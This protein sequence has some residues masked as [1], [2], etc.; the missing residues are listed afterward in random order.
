[1]ASIFK[2]PNGTW[3]YRV[4]I[5]IDPSTGKRKQKY[6]SGFSTQKK[7]KLAASQV[8]IDVSEKTYVPDDL[9]TFGQFS[10]EWLAIYSAN[11]KPTSRKIRQNQIHVLNRFFKRIRLQDITRR[12]YQKALTSL[13]SDGMANNT[14]SGIHAAARMI[15]K[16]A[17]EF[18]VIADNPTDFVKPPKKN[19]TVDEVMN[20]NAK[21]LEKD[22]LIHFLNTI[23]KENEY[24]IYELF[25]L[26]AY[27]GMR[28]GELCALT[29][30][31]IDFM[32]KTV[33]ISK[34]IYNDNNHRT[35]EF[36]PPKTKR[37]IRTIIVDDVV[38]SALSAYQKQQK[39]Y[40]MRFADSYYTK[41]PMVFT[42]KKFP[43]YP[44]AR[45]YIEWKIKYYL[46]KAG[47]PETFTPHSLRHTHVSL[48]AEAGV[49]LYD[50]MDRLGHANDST[51]RE[52]YLHVTKEKKKTASD[53]FAALLTE[54]ALK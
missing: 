14:L 45:T 21:Y 43:G 49:D 53:K 29:W 47:L 51:T 3:A 2:A 30:N 52:I 37:S 41:Y 20:M 6:A 17:V 11:V 54:A 35:F 38:F 31:D 34:T 7:A 25:L 12:H 1:M 15:F 44:V 18:N 26:L 40:R 24:Q 9:V 22:E 27:T 48:L 16:K 28:V 42:S 39:I 8:Q 33:S 13:F 19:I 10:E 32:N 46:K 36:G 5:G 50:I 23:K 4:D